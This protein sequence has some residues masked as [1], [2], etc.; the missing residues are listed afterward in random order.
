MALD[1]EQL[2][3]KIAED[4][5]TIKTKVEDKEARIIKLEKNQEWLV[6]LVIGAVVG[7]ALSLLFTTIK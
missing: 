1:M 4:V 2:I 6:R 5:A 7:A 3:L